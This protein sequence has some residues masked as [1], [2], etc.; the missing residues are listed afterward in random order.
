MN[1]KTQKIIQLIIM[2]GKGFGATRSHCQEVLD[3]CDSSFYEYVRELRDLGFCIECNHNRY[4]LNA[5]ESEARVFSGLFPLD[6]EDEFLLN[7]AIEGLNHSSKK[8]QRLLL[9]LKILF[10]EN[11]YIDKFLPQ[12]EGEMLR[13]VEKSINNR[14]QIFVEGYASGKSLKQKEYRLEAFHILDGLEMF[15]AYDV[16]SKTNKLFKFSRIDKIIEPPFNYEF[17]RNHQKSVVDD[18]NFGGNPDKPVCFELDFLARNLLIEEY[19][20]SEKNLRETNNQRFIYESQCVSF[21]GPA[22]FVLGFSGHCY[23]LGGDEFKAIVKEKSR[24]KGYPAGASCAF[25]RTILELSR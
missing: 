3:L 10:S 21:E 19:P 1:T 8:Q 18:F 16:L 13:I 6:A 14:K 2:L 15:W 23:V 7:R 11:E 9:K 5:D 4:K 20:R 17:E 12:K 25:N 24:K 22:R